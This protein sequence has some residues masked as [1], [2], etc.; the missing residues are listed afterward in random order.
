MRKRDRKD[1]YER[2][3][4]AVVGVKSKAFKVRPIVEALPAVEVQKPKT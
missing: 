2:E 1:G 4:S 3:E